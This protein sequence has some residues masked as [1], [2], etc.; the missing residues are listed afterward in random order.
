MNIAQNVVRARRIFP[1]NIALSFE[2]TSWTYEALDIQTNR[3][4]N[5]MHTLGIKQGDRVALFLPNMPAFV[6]SYLGLQKIG[7]IVVSINSSLKDGEVRFILQDAG[8]VAVITSADLVTGLPKEMPET[9]RHVLV[10]GGLAEGPGRPL[11]ELV[12]NASPEYCLVNP[13]VEDPA[14]II[15]TSGTTGFPK[16]ATLSHGN[17]ISNMHSFNYNCGMRPDDRLLLFLPLFHCFGQNAVMNS[18]FNVGATLLLHRLFKPEEVHRAIV[19]DKTTM[20]FGV[21]TTF[22]P[23]YHRVS[24]KEMAGVRYF[25]SAAA[26]L[27]LEIAEKWRA[28]YKSPVHEGYGLTETS[29]FASYNHLLKFRPGS[30]GMPIENVAMRIVDEAGQEAA[31][32]ELGEITIKGPNVMLGYWNRPTETAAVI[33]D[34]WFHSGDLGRMDEDGYFFIVDRVKDMINV[35]GLKVYPAEVEHVLYQHPAIDQAAVY[36]VPDDTMGERVWANVVLHEGASVTMEALQAFCHEE[37]ANFKVP[38]RILFVDSL[39]MNPVGKL[40]KRV[41]R[42]QAAQ[43]LGLIKSTPEIGHANNP[44]DEGEIKAWLIK[45]VAEKNGLAPGLVEIHKPFWDHGMNSIQAVRLTEDLSV[46]LGQRVNP[47]LLWNF[48]SIA[49]FT[50][51]LVNCGPENEPEVEEIPTET[52]AEELAGLSDEEMARMLA[53]ELSDSEEDGGE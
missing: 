44:H 49:S 14:A 15:Y 51:R 23:I 29:P 34:G 18:C 20:F 13:H 50:E 26:I 19:E 33:K 24:P 43:T 31:A 48:P 41:L 6:F 30:I 45:W 16:G 39:P 11:E 47:I 42:E 7:A 12:D 52:N 4:A 32:G 46:W 10:A 17:V 8:A 5:G 9:L 37:I 3:V 1:K 38:G 27:P 21:P 36:G 53:E 25:F 40:L 28:K 2:G 35:G 22:L